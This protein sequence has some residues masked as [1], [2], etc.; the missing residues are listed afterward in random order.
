[1]TKLTDAQIHSLRVAGAKGTCVIDDVR[2]KTTWVQDEDNKVFKMIR[3]PVY[4]G[5]TRMELIAY[6]YDV[7][8]QSQI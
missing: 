4:G 6:R 5:P 8:P 3:H 1:M 2:G 7:F